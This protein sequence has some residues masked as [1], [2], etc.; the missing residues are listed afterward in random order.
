MNH[1]TTPP[2]VPPAVPGETPETAPIHGGLRD[3]FE[4]L[5]RRPRDLAT[6]PLLEA[7]GTF[8]RLALIALAAMTIFGFV[9]GTF[10]WQ[11]Q[12]WAAP[13]KLA[14]GLLFAGVIC[15]PSLYIF[16]CLAG[17]HSSAL[18]LATLLTAMLALT[19]VLLLGFAPAVWIFTQGTT[20]FGFMGVLA[21]GAWLVSFLFGR[22]FL[23]LALQSHGASQRGPLF[24][25][26]VIFLLVTLQLTTSLRPILGT[27]DRFMTTEKK[28]FLAHWA[29]SSVLSLGEEEEATPESTNNPGRPTR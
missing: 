10:A 5:L 9:L 2:P 11:D 28:F 6:H 29:E 1:E 17:S 24:I 23:A 3:L 15:F 14:S 25:W 26:S 7:P 18:R 19:G 21:I 27:S 13:L 12:I 16:S 8:L 4:A 20:S 22:R